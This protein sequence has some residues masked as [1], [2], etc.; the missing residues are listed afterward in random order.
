MEEVDAEEY[1]GWLAYFAIE[2]FGGHV[3]D[4]RSGL[5]VSA[6]AA[7]L[8]QTID[9]LKIFGWH[10]KQAESEQAAQ[11]KLEVQM[12]KNGFDVRKKE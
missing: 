8:G 9:P 7:G 12:L 4:F 2:P 10:G 6:I 3:E 5:I 1:A 11:R